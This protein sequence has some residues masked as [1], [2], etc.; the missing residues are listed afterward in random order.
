MKITLRSLFIL[1][2]QLLTCT[3]A[4]AQTI[5]PWTGGDDG[6]AI[7]N[8]LNK[9]SSV[10]LE[11]GKVYQTSIYLVIPSDRTF[12]GN[13]STIKPHVALPVSNTALIDTLAPWYAKTYTSANINIPVVCG[14]T[15]FTYN[16]ASN[17]KAGQIVEIWGNKYYLGSS[18]AEYYR[19][20][21][22]GLVTSVSGNTVTLLNKSVKS[23]EG[24]QIMAFNPAKNV[25]LKNLHI[26]VR[27]RTTGFGVSFNHAINSRMDNVSVEGDDNST[28]GVR[29]G[30]IA[31]GV[32]IVIDK[33]SVKNIRP[34]ATGNGVY[35]ID[36]EGHN[37]IVSNPHVRNVE[38]CITSAGRDYFSTDI[39]FLNVDVD[40][41]KGCGHSLDF[42][43]NASGTMKGG[44]VV[45]GVT[46]TGPIS[47]RN[48]NATV[49]DMVI[50]IPNQVG[51]SNKRG[52]FIFENAVSNIFIS[53]NRFEYNS[54]SGLCY[55]VGNSTDCPAPTRNL[56][57]L[58]NL[59]LGC[60]VSFSAP[61]NDV[62]I[63]GNWFETSDGIQSR[64]GISTSQPGQYRILNNKFINRTSASIFNYCISTS[65]ANGNGTVKNNIV[66]QMDKANNY[67]PFRF[68]NTAN[69]VQYN[70]AYSPMGKFIMDYSSNPSANTINNNTLQLYVGDPG[71]RPVIPV[72]TSPTTS[73]QTREYFIDLGPST[74][75][76]PQ[77]TA[78][79]KGRRWNNLTSGS[80]NASAGNLVD[81]K[82]TAS[83]KSIKI[84]DSF[85]DNVSGSFN[86]NGTKS[87][88]LYAST[89]TC[90]SFFIGSHLGVVDNTAK[91]RLSGL[92][93][94][95][96]YKIRLYASRMTSD[97]TTGRTTVYSINGSTH[98]LNALN[99]VDNYVEFA[100][101]TATNGVLDITC[102]VKTGS[103]Y[104]YLGLI[105][106]IETSPIN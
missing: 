32:N 18:T 89:A 62:E 87:S 102:S 65:K 71:T 37:V 51:M 100:G 83:T 10:M 47:I 27:G 63:S 4:Q 69:V 30:I 17:I 46:G 73:L 7:Q 95:G 79:A 90:D 75:A 61:L 5:V 19:D 67:P 104:G 55:A 44:T 41:M 94:D 2:M 39:Q 16:G 103:K 45:S 40:N 74:K 60:D 91:L 96:T 53:N 99:N 36:V 23:F 6:P 31:T 93:T 81:S 9:Y 106:I 35:G 11:A 14:S 29:A 64:I 88:T 50:K 28:T 84:T 82:G 52:I 85:W 86:A 56:K 76:S 105:H 78:D 20:G 24:N 59:F 34:L 21:W 72:L 15:T 1:S 8:S 101:L 54:S 97:L 3:L 13:G 58:N 80:L 25:Y 98:E 42:H 77:T 70:L 22:F 66:Y 26:D 12:D 33:A 38:T 48:S 57:I 49:S 68:N 92:R 43:G